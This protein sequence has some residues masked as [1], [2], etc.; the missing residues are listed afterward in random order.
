MTAEKPKEDYVAFRDTDAVNTRLDGELSVCQVVTGPVVTQLRD[1][2]EVEGDPDPDVHSSRDVRD[3]LKDRI[4]VSFVEAHT[5]EGVR[6]VPTGGRNRLYSPKVVVETYGTI[7][8]S[9]EGGGGSF[10]PLG[11]ER[12]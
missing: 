7:C 8:T 10:Y 9:P 11:P 4:G 12:P 6:V 5:S 3:L 2:A 1:P